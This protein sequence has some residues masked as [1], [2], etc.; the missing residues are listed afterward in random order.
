MIQR[1]TVIDKLNYLLKIPDA[2]RSIEPGEIVL[3]AR[4]ILADTIVPY[5]W[6]DEQLSEFVNDGV[7]EIKN[8]RADVERMTSVPHPFTSAL[9]NYVVYRAFSI[10]N[11]AQ[12]NNGAI[13]DKYMN[14]FREQAAAIK[15][16]FTEDDLTEFIDEA[17]NLIIARRPE[18]RI[19]ENG[20]LKTAI[21]VNSEYDLPE[22]FTDVIVSGAAAKAAAHSKNEM[23]QYF[24]EQ[25]TGALQTI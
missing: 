5:R 17:V 11:D 1:S 6:G 10:D 18:L 23:A 8:L 3:R 14:L 15:Y 16:F 4:E 7:S 2:T 9:S 19:A 22:R 24:S 13:S 21:I 12:N 20:T 25:F